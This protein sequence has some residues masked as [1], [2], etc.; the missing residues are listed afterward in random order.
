MCMNRRKPKM[1]GGNQ[2]R[3]RHININFLVRLLLGHPGNVPGDK[4]GLSPGQSGFVPG[5]NPGFLFILH[6]GSPVRPWDKP[7]LSLGHSG[8]EGQLLKVYV[9]LSFSLGKG[10]LRSL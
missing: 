4:P 7:S 8:D 10:T 6:S 9:P 1:E 5:T 3:K 2:A